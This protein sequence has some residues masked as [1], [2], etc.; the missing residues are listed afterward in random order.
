MCYN[1]FIFIFYFLNIVLTWK[2]VVPAKVSVLYIY[3]DDLNKLW[4]MLTSALRALVNN[5]F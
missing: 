2:I 4:V 3:I 1:V 5:P